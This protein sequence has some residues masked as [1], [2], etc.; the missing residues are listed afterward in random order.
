[1]IVYNT[2]PG[3]WPGLLFMV[4]MWLCV[5]DY[6]LLFMHD[7]TGMPFP[8]GSYQGKGIDAC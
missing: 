3:L 2:N 5:I 7:L 4:C 1:M 8:I 6:V